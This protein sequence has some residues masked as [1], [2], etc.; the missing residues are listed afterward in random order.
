[1]GKRLSSVLMIVVVVAAFAAPVALSLFL[2][3]RQAQDQEEKRALE[4]AHD[5]VHRTE[6]MLEQVQ[7]GIARLDGAGDPCSDGKLDAMR[8][9]DL[10]SSYIQAIGRTSGDTLVCSSLGVAP[11]TGVALGPLDLEVSRGARIRYD[12]RFPFSGDTRFL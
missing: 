4:Y 7:A 2:A 5:V 9:V 11:G 3:Q 10:A 1:M 12:V 6:G 8:K